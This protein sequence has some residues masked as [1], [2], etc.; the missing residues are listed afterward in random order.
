MT[1]W[2]WGRCVTAMLATALVSACADEGGPNEI[3]S[4]GDAGS[5]VLG[6]AGGSVQATL[7]GGGALELTVPAG[8][9]QD[10]VT[11]TITP[12]TPA[13]GE[14][15]AFQVTPGGLE[16]ATPASFEARLPAGTTLDPSATFVFDVGTLHVPFAAVV[17]PVGG[18]VT[19][20]IARLGASEIAAAPASAPQ[21][22]P[23]SVQRR[24][25][26][27]PRWTTRSA[28]PS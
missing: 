16:F 19:V 12:L 18:R 15:A 5:A 9:L 27:S 26:R 11:I 22:L 24:R 1:D 6:A 7:A 14:Y 21:R 2:L 23:A 25:A 20:S 8:A 10:T 28:R 17:D 13:A 3:P 4:P